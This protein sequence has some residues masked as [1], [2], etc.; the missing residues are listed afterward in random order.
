MDLLTEIMSAQGGAAVQQLGS[1][2][3]LGEQQ[4]AAA[5]SALIP[6]LA[7]GVQQNAQNEGGFGNLISALSGGTHQQYLNSPET[8]G[9]PAAVAEGNGIL[10]HVLGDKAVSREVASR[11][12]AQ[13]GISFDVLKRM[14]PLAATLLMGAL[15]RRS[16]NSAGTGLNGGGIASMLGPL[17]DS[18]R[19]GS[20]VD[21]VTGMIGRFLKKR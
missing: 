15:A 19:D 12:A 7:A 14:L 16:S 11:A 18:N 17:L 1:Q 9:D 10:G 6:A 20:I 5:L 8:L 21:D 13:T 3:G 4:T 2:F